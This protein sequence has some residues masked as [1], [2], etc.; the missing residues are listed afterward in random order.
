MQVQDQCCSNE[1]VEV[2]AGG[3]FC[4]PSAGQRMAQLT[5]HSASVQQ[6]NGD[7]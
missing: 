2:T 7:S 3:Y 4:F 1:A 5:K 6:Q